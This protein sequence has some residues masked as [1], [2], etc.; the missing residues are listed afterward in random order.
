M[1]RGGARSLSSLFS[2]CVDIIQ[3]LP[4]AGPIQTSYEEKLELYGYVSELA[5]SGC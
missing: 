3:S 4:A 1:R 2:R 5:A